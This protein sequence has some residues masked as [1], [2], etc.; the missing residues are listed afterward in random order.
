MKILITAVFLMISSF[1][2]SCETLGERS[3]LL[4]G[5]KIE[6]DVLNRPTVKLLVKEVGPIVVF[7]A[8]VVENYAGFECEV[9]DALRLSQGCWEIQVQ[10]SPGADF[11][12]CEVEASTDSGSVYNA[13]LYMDYHGSI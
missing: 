11:S 9:V 10:W 4:D 13:F 6:V 7:S 5:E 1:S 2:Y 12:G 8:R 3:L